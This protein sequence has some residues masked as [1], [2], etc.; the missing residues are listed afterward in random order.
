M[1]ADTEK[2]N[3]IIEFSDKNGYL[4]TSYPEAERLTLPS[5]STPRIRF[6]KES[7]DGF[8]ETHTDESYIYDGNLYLTFDMSFYY[9][10]QPG[11]QY[12]KIEVTFEM[13]DK[14]VTIVEETHYV[15]YEYNNFVEVA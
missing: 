1:Q 5:K 3:E 10:T 11:K 4:S 15:K 8:L 14:E 13:K 9:R 12:E 7:K 6:Y 2:F